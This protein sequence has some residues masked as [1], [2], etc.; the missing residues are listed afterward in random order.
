MRV[1]IVLTATLL[2][3]PIFLTLWPPAAYAAADAA[4]YQFAGPG[5]ALSFEGRA[6]G[7]GVGLCQWGAR[8]RAL[9]GQTAEQIVGAYY[10]G[11]T[12]QPAVSPDQ[13]IRVLLYGDLRLNPGEAS[14]IND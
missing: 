5:Q 14:R 9:A 3:A 7:H 12:I 13:T 1:V 8:G 2:L 4:A 6:W 10:Q 11:A